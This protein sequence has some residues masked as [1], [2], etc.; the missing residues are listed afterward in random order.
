MDV[1][2]KSKAVTAWLFIGLCMVFF[3]VIIGGITRLT[4]SGLSITKWEVISGTLPPLSE[5]Q[6]VH[7]F[8]LYK[9][10]PQ[11]AEVNEGMSESDFRFIYFWEYIHR[12]WARLMG[13]VF[14]IPFLYFLKKNKLSPNLKK[15]LL[16]V[17]AL[18]GLAAIFGWIMVASGLVDRPWVNAYK[19][20]LHLI[21]ALSVFLYL[22]ITILRYTQFSLSKE[23]VP[24]SYPVRKVLLVF[25][26]FLFF[27]ILVGG[28]LSGMKA[29]VVY[30]TW[31]DL[32]GEYIPQVLFNADLWNLQSFIE[33]DKN[34][35]LPAL[36]HT[37]H[38]TTG[39]ILWVIGLI[40]CWNMWL[41]YKDQR[42]VAILRV[43]VFFFMMLHL[44][45]L[46]GIITVV[47]SVGKIPVLWGELH[48]AGVLMLAGIVCLLIFSSV[49]EK[50]VK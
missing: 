22:L 23:D 45:I 24:L 1:V 26:S 10:T 43:S 33:Y 20:S 39:Y 47:K 41:W 38:R 27:Q 17:V 6:W 50:T 30:P 16:V 37:V 9:Q 8:E 36:V 34:P 32:Y 19:L 21:I 48:Q 42:E 14:L 12:F 40:L 3:Q 7:E 49:P 46:L 2:N 29:A 28:I 13:F 18:A 31:P 4:E 15:D 5:E 35:L 25:A 11:Y 44:Q